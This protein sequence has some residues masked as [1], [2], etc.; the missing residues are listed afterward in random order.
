MVLCR[1]HAVSRPDDVELGLRID[2]QRAIEIGRV[3]ASIV[4][5][6]AQTT[7]TR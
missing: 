1:E 5:D 2:L 4:A 6:R 3:H 7:T